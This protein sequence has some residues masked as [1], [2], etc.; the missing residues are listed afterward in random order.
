M[1]QKL[2]QKM[3]NKKFAKES[4]ELFNEFETFLRD[5]EA[6]AGYEKWLDNRD[7]SDREDSQNFIMSRNLRRQGVLQDGEFV[8]GYTMGFGRLYVETSFGYELVVNERFEVLKVNKLTNET[9]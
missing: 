2:T 7:N 3:Q 5:K 4:L 9:R 1:D 8:T 6:T